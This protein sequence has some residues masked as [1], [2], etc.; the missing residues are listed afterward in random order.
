MLLLLPSRQLELAETEQRLSR[1]HCLGSVSGLWPLCWL[2][3]GS[4]PSDEAA[5]GLSPGQDKILIQERERARWRVA[6]SEWPGQD[7]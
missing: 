3:R 2:L 5:P 6:S 4:R 1:F 7:R